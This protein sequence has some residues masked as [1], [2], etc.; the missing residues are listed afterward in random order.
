MKKQFNQT[1]QK[2]YE[3]SNNIRH[4]ITGASVP[5]Y[6][7]RLYNLLRD[8]TIIT[9]QDLQALSDNICLVF[10]VKPI[11]ITFAGRQPHTHTGK[12]LKRKI[13]G[14]ER[15]SIFMNSIKIYKY[16]AVRQKE[17]S[18]KTAISTLLHELNHYLDY[19]L[20]KLDSIHC[21][22][23]YHRIGQTVE[24]LTN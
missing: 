3:K 9:E 22:G 4:I 14:T 10:E 15:H 6:V 8:K 11:S 7:K 20:Y 17:L 16:T 24:L 5:N 12:R 13:L 18:P 2:N 19:V 1:S 23:F 21:S